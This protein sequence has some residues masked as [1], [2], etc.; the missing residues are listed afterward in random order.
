MNALPEVTDAKDDPFGAPPLRRRMS[1]TLKAL[2]ARAALAVTFVVFVLLFIAPLWIVDRLYPAGDLT[3]H[4]RFALSAKSALLQGQLSYSND[5]AL[6]LQPSFLYYSPLYLAV[7][8]LAQIAFGI[9]AYKGILSAITLFVGVGMIGVYGSLRA[10]N[11]RPSSAAIGSA[12]FAFAPY[13]LTDIFVRSALAEVAAFGCFPLLVWAFLALCR[14]PSVG[15]LLWCTAAL[16]LFILAHKIFIVWGVGFLALLGFLL[17]GRRAIRPI[18]LFAIASAAAMCI[19]AYYWANS[20]LAVSHLWLI[21]DVQDYTQAV[22]KFHDVNFDG[23]ISQIGMMWTFV[24]SDLSVFYPFRHVHARAQRGVYL[25][26][27]PVATV[28]LLIACFYYYRSSPRAFLL[29]T[30]ISIVL[31]CSVF[32]LVPLWRFAPTPLTVVQ[33]PYR[34]LLFA[35]T[36][37]AILVGLVIHETSHSRRGVVIAAWVALTIAAMVQV[38]NFIRP[39]LFLATA[40]PAEAEAEEFFHYDYWEPGGPKPRPQTPFADAA[41]SVKKIKDNRVDLIVSVQRPGLVPLPVL[42]SRLLV[43]EGADANLVVLNA[44]KH[45]AVELHEGVYQLV[46]QRREPIGRVTGIAAG[47]GILLLASLLLTRLQTPR[48][49]GQKLGTA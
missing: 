10:L 23:P 18:A 1:G 39:P 40:T 45:A 15:Q 49:Y 47:C 31:A 36:F 27:G 42:Y 2:D 19:T 30:L 44:D 34:L 43:I 14:Q 24:N 21:Q 8:G 32:H 25:Q 46:V 22:G 17:Y 26:I 38:I 3:F 29:V 9:S 48:S 33:F 28:G 11:A 16:V 6:L 7:S 37:G 12:V 35:S 13:L 5:G 20:W 41:E 4:I